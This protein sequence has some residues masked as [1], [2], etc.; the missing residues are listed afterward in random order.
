MSNPKR[1]MKDL[2][3]L[4]TEMFDK[5]PIEV[6]FKQPLSEDDF[7]ETGMKAYLTGAE[8]HTN[9]IVK[10]FFYFDDHFDTN[11]KLFKKVFYDHSKD[12]KKLYTAFESDNYDPYYS[13]FVGAEEEIFNYFVPTGFSALAGLPLTSQTLVYSFE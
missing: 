4:L 11:K 10:L 8:T 13:V 2:P 9:E 6:V 1:K 3:N 7:I 12:D 5:L